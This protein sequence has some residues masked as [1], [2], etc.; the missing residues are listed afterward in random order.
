MTGR[1]FGYDKDT[2]TCLAMQTIFFRLP[3]RSAFFC[4]VACASFGQAGASS[5]TSQK[6]RYIAILT[7]M[8][9]LCRLISH[10]GGGNGSITLVSLPML[11]CQHT[12]KAH[13]FNSSLFLDPRILQEARQPEQNPKFLYV[14][15]K[16]V[17][18]IKP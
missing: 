4:R 6:H 9:E 3:C 1:A 12:L 16:L 7:T 8:C 18:K 14:G 17:S 11:G 15:C 5:R 13:L 2:L 10:G